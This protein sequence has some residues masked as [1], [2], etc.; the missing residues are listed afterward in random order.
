MPR[1][2]GGSYIDIDLSSG[3][4]KIGE[5]KIDLMEEYIGGKWFAAY[6]LYNNLDPRIDPLSPENIILVAAGPV[7]GSK[8][9]LAS[10]K[11][12]RAHV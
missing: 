7:T 8:I 3:A 10:K 5:T 12:G 6:Y 2:Y 1:G 11:I 4:I 9:P